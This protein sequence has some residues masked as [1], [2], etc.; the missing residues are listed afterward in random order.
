[1]EN[2]CRISATRQ[3]TE[4]LALNFAVCSQV[5]CWREPEPSSVIDPIQ[6]FNEPLIVDPKED[7][8]I[9]WIVRRKF[10]ITSTEGG[11]D[12]YPNLTVDQFWVH[13][14]RGNC[15][16]RL[17]LS[18]IFAVFTIFSVMIDLLSNFLIRIAIRSSEPTKKPINV[19]SCFG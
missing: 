10:L 15:L 13:I 17:S 3:T 16:A 8:L 2:R 6:K 9:L 14:L 11:A 7:F 1:M 4:L 5:R 18:S 12:V 19:P